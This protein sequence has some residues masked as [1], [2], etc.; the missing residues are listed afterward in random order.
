MAARPST[1]T[2][3]GG[4]TSG[5]ACTG[6]FGAGKRDSSS[7][8]STD[9][10]G[11]ISATRGHSKAVTDQ[12]GVRSRTALNP[13]DVPTDHKVSEEL[14]RM[15]CHLSLARRASLDDLNAA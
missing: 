2:P 7:D 6:R 12:P 1:E 8:S 11:R 9:T 15:R 13:C 14:A 5:G 10:R 4:T 3:F